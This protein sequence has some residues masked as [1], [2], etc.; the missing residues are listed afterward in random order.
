MKT[1]LFAVCA[2]AALYAQQPMSE[3]PPVM[4]PMQQEQPGDPPSRV[5]RLNFIAGDVAFQPATVDD[6]S[7][8]T[9]NYPLTTGDHLFVNPGARAELHIDGS[10]VRLNS[11]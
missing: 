9:V 11:N 8:A 10:A 3:Q 1:I 7:A 5:A 4:Q 2:S 6:W